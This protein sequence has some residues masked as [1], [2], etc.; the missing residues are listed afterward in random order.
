MNPQKFLILTAGQS[1]MSGRGTAGPDDLQ[2][3]PGIRVFGSDGAWHTSGEPVCRDKPDLIGLFDAEGRHIP[4]A[5]DAPWA[6]PCPPGHS[7]RGVGPARTFA[8][9]L[10]GTLPPG[11]EIGIIPTSF[12]GSSITQ[13]EPAPP[14]APPSHY[15]NALALARGA[16][17]DGGAISVILWHQGEADLYRGTADYRERLLALIRRFRD[18]LGL[19]ETVPFLTGELGGFLSE[20]HPKG[21]QDFNA[22][23][24]A[25]AAEFPYIGCAAAEDLPHRGDF[26]HFNTEAQHRLGERYFQEYLRITRANPSA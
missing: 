20:R 4:Q 9:L 13:W 12:G 7:I 2:D 1:N 15:D 22:G 19:P 8:R 26:L 10:L 3:I 17:A 23:L 18:D 14:D 24:R 16:L 5:P 25:L 21:P 11:S 6:F